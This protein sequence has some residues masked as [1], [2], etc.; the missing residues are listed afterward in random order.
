MVVWVL[1]VVG[2]SLASLMTSMERSVGGFSRMKLLSGVFASFSRKCSASTRA[3]A[4]VVGDSTAQIAPPYT[5]HCVESLAPSV[6][7]IPE[8]MILSLMME[9]AFFRTVSNCS[10]MFFTSTLLL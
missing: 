6:I 10:I 5:V 9:E 2:S 1:K 7:L 4:R 8:H 3:D